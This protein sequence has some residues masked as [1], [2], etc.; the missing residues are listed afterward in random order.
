MVDM[1]NLDA[2]I[3]DS[4]LYLGHGH[5]NKTV[6]QCPHGPTSTVLSSRGRPAVSNNCDPKY[7]T[8]SFFM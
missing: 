2:N 3:G 1:G 4:F 5:H 8:H 7:K 6:P